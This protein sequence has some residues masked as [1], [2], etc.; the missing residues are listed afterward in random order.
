MNLAPN[1]EQGMMREMLRRFLGDRY[2]ATTMAKGPISSA[3]WRALGELG[4][5]AFL[6]PER[7]G[8][9][10]AGPED[11]MLV[12][13]EMGRSLA[14]TPLAESVLLCARL[15]GQYGTQAQIDRWVE[16]V[17]NGLSMLAFAS[18]GSTNGERLT[19]DCGL[20]REG[21]AAT[22]FVVA[23][24]GGGAV[25]V[26]ADAEGVG[27]TQVRLVDGSIAAALSFEGAPCEVVE[28]PAG[29]LAESTGLAELAVV[30]ETVGAMGTLF[31]LTLDYVKQRKQ[32][33]AILGSFQAIQHRCARLYILVEQA[34][35][36]MIKASLAEPAQ[37]ADALLAARAYVADAALRLAEDAV[38]LHGGMGVTEE[39]AVGRGLRRVLL[40]TR[41][42][43]GAADA[44]AKLAA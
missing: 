18:G 37:R 12:A 36:M 2:D 31:D 26:A 7:A 21:M 25:L 15:L 44:R 1:E 40:L 11:V 13:E 28:I 34:R 20:V 29:A 4:L 35:S 5:L 39:L 16:P 8:G 23:T 10:D 32:F 43:G 19:G 41:L 3:D 30:A 9:M 14:I 42:F 24:E 33:G 38:Q 22:G 6:L 17:I 27:R